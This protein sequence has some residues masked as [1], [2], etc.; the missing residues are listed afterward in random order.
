[1]LIFYF[2]FRT[3]NVVLRWFSLESLSDVAALPIVMV[4]FI[5]F[6]V[7]MQPIDNFISRRFEKEADTM[8]IKTTGLKDAFISTMDKLGTQNLADRRPH[9]AIKLFFFDHPPIDER[10]NLA[11]KL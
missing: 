11:K 8:A 4:Y 6:G 9:P 10:I 2:I 3:S 7:I 5:L 1:M